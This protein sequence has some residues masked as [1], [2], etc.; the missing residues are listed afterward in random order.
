ME[1]LVKDWGLKFNLSTGDDMES[2]VFI[3]INESAEDLNFSFI[4]PKDCSYDHAKKGALTI[5]E[6]LVRLESD[7][8]KALAEQKAAEEAAA[9]PVEVEAELASDP[10][11]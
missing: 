7:A 11:G 9:V 3:K 5:Y 1:A 10:I 6:H 8:Q 2:Q 4:I